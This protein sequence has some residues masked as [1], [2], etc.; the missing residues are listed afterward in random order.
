MKGKNI[1]LV[2]TG[3]IVG[4][5]S[6]GVLTTKKIL[7]NDRTRD[8][9]RQIIADKVEQILFGDTPQ[10]KNCSGVNYRSYYDFKNSRPKTPDGYSHIHFPSRVDA[11]NAL[12]EMKDIINQYGVVTIAD[13]YELSGNHNFVYNSSKYGWVNV[14][15]C[16]IVRIK[17]GFK[18]DLPD[19]LPLN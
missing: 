4:F 14:D 18:I 6:C 1:I 13:F 16:K 12:D 7:E 17:D 10:P 5:I 15:R 19:P 9:L 3:A 11:E 2:G 8:A